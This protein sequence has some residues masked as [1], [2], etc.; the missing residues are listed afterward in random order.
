MTQTTT[1]TGSGTKPGQMT[2]VMRAMNQ[3]PGPKVLRVGVVLGGKVIEERIIKQRTHVTIGPSEKSMFVTPNKNVPPSFRLFELV[4]DEYAL[5]FLEGMSGRVA[6]KTGVTDLAS[7]KSQAKK[8]SFG[9][10]QAFQV[11]LSDDARGKIVVGDTTFLFQF[12]AAPPPQPKPQLPAS[13][14]GGFVQ[15]IDWTTT[16]IAAFS[17]LLHFGAVGT[18][19]SDWMDPLVN[20]EV[21]VAQIL[22]SVRS[23]PPPP[24]VEQPKETD[25]TPTQAST[26]Q[27][28]APK[29]SAGASAA[30]GAGGG[31]ISDARA[32]AIANE[33]A[34]LD[35]QMLGA[36]NAS[37][38][39][40]AGVLDRGDVPLGLLD[41]A[42]ASGAGAGLGGIA[43]LN[44]GA[45]GGGT[46]RPGAA[47]GGGLA[48]IGD[49]QAATAA[50]AQ[51][52][53]KTVK[54]PTGSANVGGAAVSGGNVANASSVVAGM[55]A[56]FRRCYNRGL[57]S[58]PTMKGSVRITAKIGPN[59]E[60]LSA[61]PSGGG[62]LSGEVISC[63]VARVQSAQFAPPEGGGATVVIPVSFVSQ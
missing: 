19:Y 35:M 3:A 32:S 2:A 55:A 60:V 53:V 30:K 47:G 37:G 14:R 63:V 49:T 62:G 15:S 44:L 33:L 29:P 39:A 61:S 54:G 41:N 4:G 51:G 36:L 45:A 20:D 26:A 48:S 42:A 9:N 7:L 57:Q 5:N 31:K 22:E 28:E 46:V 34:Q 18:I 27:A 1:Q 25:T 56:G 17:F 11:P 13:V 58:D 10:T 52:A 43:G 16:I 50:S 8:V 23:L 21:D 59:G 12:V 6:L 24:P 38:N 40:T